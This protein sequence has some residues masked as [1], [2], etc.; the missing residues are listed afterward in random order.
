M[1]L[2]GGTHLQR[3]KATGK[4]ATGYLRHLHVN[5]TRALMTFFLIFPTVVEGPTHLFAQKRFSEDFLISIRLISNWTSCR[6]IQGV[7]GMIISDW[8]RRATRSS[9][10]YITRRLLSELH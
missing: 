3:Q 2:V 9:E 5:Y 7:I 1:L 8:P 4:W 10:F 6:P